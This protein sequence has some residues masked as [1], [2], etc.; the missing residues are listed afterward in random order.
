MNMPKTLHII[1][2][3]HW[4]REW[5]MSFEQHRA[6]L[7]ELIDTLIDTMESNPEYTSFHLD[8]QYIIIEDYLN[9][10]P[11]MKERLLKL[12]QADRIQIGPW[13]VLQDEFL[14]SGEA[15][16]R[17]ML[18]GLRF[19]RAIGANPV[20][21]GYFPDSF[22]NISQAPQIL[23]GFG[24]D[25]A[26]FGR[27]IGVILPDNKVVETATS[28]PSEIVWRAPDGSE[29]LG[30]MFAYWYNNAMELSADP[31]KLK[32]QLQVL[33]NRSISSAATPHLLGMNGCDHEPAQTNLPAVIKMANQ[34]LEEQQITVRQSCFKEYLE[35]LWPYYAIF[36]SVEGELCGQNSSGINLLI[37]TASTRIPIK[38][39]NHKVQNLL[40]QQAEPLNVL[41]SL[42]GDS[43][44][45]DLLIYAWKKMMENQPHDTKS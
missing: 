5:Y 32:Q 27:G 19:C 38:Q 29:V 23:R 30:V 15:N 20:M 31:D 3:V 12:I 39:Q 16:I 4:D 13:Y 18:Y 22:G 26:V 1:P 7:V 24:I 43:Y 17:N 41:S 11:Q 6:R 35:Q 28:Y 42:A 25:N 45:M 9:I 44:R 2:H 10:R 37:N 34:M 36:S 21:S 33:L 14:T 40:T 8:G